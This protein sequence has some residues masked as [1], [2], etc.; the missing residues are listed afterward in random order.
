M[1]KDELVI[2]KEKALAMLGGHIKQWKDG[3]IEMF[4]LQGKNNINLRFSHTYE[5]GIGYWFGITPGA[6]SIFEKNNI[7]DICFILGVEGIAKLP[8]DMIKQYIQNADKSYKDEHKG[9]V[10]HYHIRFKVLDSVLLYNSTEE[11]DVSN[12]MEYDEVVYRRLYDDDKDEK[13]RNEAEQ[14]KDFEEPYSGDITVK[15]RKES[16]KQKQ[17]VA[18][19]EQYTCQVCSF[20][21]EFQNKKG[22]KLYI[23][24][25]DHIIEKSKG[26]GE[27]MDN[28]WVL[29]PNCHSK[30]TF[31]VITIDIEKKEVREN[32]KIINIRDNHLGW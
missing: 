28:L 13:L 24:H 31:G 32:N 26:G 30:K 19:L 6:M 18:R 14:F 8:I 2:S 3:R 7:S 20:K 4:T 10:K 1:R 9:E 5:D 21:C 12:L 22:K 17:I 23:V 15:K 11:F 16:R 25:V 29:C 27:K